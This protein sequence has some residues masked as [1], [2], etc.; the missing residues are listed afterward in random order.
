MEDFRK[1]KFGCA[2]AHSEGEDYPQ[3]LRD[4]FIDIARVVD[5]ALHSSVFLFL[6]HKG[7]GKSSLSEHLK[8]TQNNTI[9]DQQGL[10]DFPFGL[11][12]KVM[13]GDDKPIRYK[14]IWKWI[15]CTKVLYNLYK[16]DQEIVEANPENKKAISIF[17]KS[18]LFPVLN[19]SSLVNKKVSTT[20]SVTLKLLGLS[21]MKE[22][23]ERDSVD[24]ETLTEYI[25]NMIL[26]I[27]EEHS[28][29]I[30]IDDLDDIL[31]PKGNQLYNI[32]ALINEVKDLNLFFR[33]SNIPIKIIVLC[34]TDMFERLPDPN[35]NK[36]K[37]DK[38][39]TFSWYREGINTQKDSDLVRLIN[40]RTQLVYPNV[41]DTFARFF[42]EKYDGK[43][44]YTALLDF[45]RHI[46]R[47]FVQL[48]NY[49]QQ[50]C[51]SSK[52]TTAEIAKGIKDYSAEYFKQEIADE[53]SGYLPGIVIEAVFNA[54]S[55]LRKQ[56]FTYAQFKQVCLYNPALKDANI[57]A[58]LKILYDCSAI[59]HIY[60]YKDNKKSRV[61]FKYRNRTSTFTPQDRIFLHKGLWKALNVNF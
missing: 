49:I 24:L 15:L 32:V 13:K 4:G 9:V 20:A 27:K 61:T 2:D 55:S 19:I 6:G 5:T 40:K 3:L 26:S 54:L 16:Y 11:F 23:T 58:V 38:S 12:E 53:M 56:Q 28:H 29:I 39:F 51:S 42:P 14:K 35:L 59:G 7:A 34:R 60:A 18:G 44:I 36:I 21:Y 8:L 22:E 25:T 47:D 17:E 31:S 57:D 1:I 37:Q 48:I 41:K 46:P 52:V 33:K 43:D 30:I 50:H 10:R 45:T